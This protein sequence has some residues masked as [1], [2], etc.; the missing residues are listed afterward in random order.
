MAE[1]INSNDKPCQ[2]RRRVRTSSR[3]PIIHSRPTPHPVACY[4]DFLS[5]DGLLVNACDDISFDDLHESVGQK[6]EQLAL[7]I[8]TEFLKKKHESEDKSWRD[9]SDACRQVSQLVTTLEKKLPKFWYYAAE[10]SRGHTQCQGRYVSRQSSYLKQYLE[11]VLD[12]EPSNHYLGSG[13]RLERALHDAQQLLSK[14]AV[15]SSDGF[16]FKSSFSSSQTAKDTFLAENQKAQLRLQELSAYEE[17]LDTE[18]QNV[19]EQLQQLRS[20]EDALDEE[21]REREMEQRQSDQYMERLER[22]IREVTIRLQM[23]VVLLFLFCKFSGISDN[24]QPMCITM[25]WNIRPALIVLW[26]V[27][28]MFYP[29]Q[30]YVDPSNTQDAEL[31][32]NVDFPGLGKIKQFNK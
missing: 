12:F 25:P 19:K 21:Q 6:Q 27:C 20:V 14:S 3:T 5:D 16:D 29:P 18:F 4:S 2:P 7:Y 9:F 1:I 32:R 22:F 11:L 13:G 8:S 10:F 28:W 30:D 17:L 23:F 24:D 26:G 31:Y 15:W